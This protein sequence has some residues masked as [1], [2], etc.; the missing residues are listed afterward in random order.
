MVFGIGGK[1]LKF[2]I[3]SSKSTPKSQGGRAPG[4]FL[5]GSSVG[6][7]CHPWGIPATVAHVCGPKAD[8]RGGANLYH[9]AHPMNLRRHFV[10][11]AVAA[12]LS[13]LAA[14]SLA[15]DLPSLLSKPIIDAALPMKQVQAFC[16]ERIPRMPKVKTVSAWERQADRMRED[17]LNNVVFRGEAKVWRDADKEVEWLET[18]PGGPG[19]KIRKLRYEVLPGLWTAALLYEPDRLNGKVPVVMNVNGHD[20]KNGKAADYKQARCINQAKRGMLA[21]NVEWL[22]MGQLNTEG[23]NHYR[24]NQLDLCGASGLA[25]FYLAMSRGIDILLAHPNADPE[26]VAVAGLSGGGWQTIFISSLDTRVTLCNPVA[27]YSSFRTRVH[28]LSDLGDSEQTPN[29]L[30][31]VTDY[32]HLTAMLAPRPA[33][34]TF[35]AEDQCCFAANHALP[36]LLA[37]ATP[38][39]KLYNAESSLRYHVNY[40]PGSHNFEVDNRQA[41]YR[42]FGEFFYPHDPGFDP[43]ELP[44]VGEIKTA[45]ELEVALPEGNLDFQKLAARAMKDLPRDGEV[46]TRAGAAGKWRREK[47]R[48]LRK[49]VNAPSYKVEAEQVGAEAGDI[50]ATQWKLQLGDEWTVPAVEL[51]GAEAGGTSIVIADGGRASAER[52]IQEL[53]NQGRRVIAVD[54]FYF[55]ESRIAKRDFLFALLVAATGERPLGIQAAQLNAIAKWAGKAGS[56]QEVS[57]VGVGPRSSLIALTAAALDSRSIDALELHRPYSSLKDVIRDNGSVQKT[58]EVFCFGLLEVV[59]IRQLIALAAPRPVAIKVD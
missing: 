42:V 23:F 14:S 35:N 9:A 46:P 15:G 59:D 6:R 44:T 2:Q 39:Y 10:S 58:P 55:G 49:A 29:D 33:L 11:L 50:T 32:A 3:P 1:R 7:L 16:D 37:A 45:G 40:D 28:N 41:L 12:G 43:H 34:L 20:R 53:L 21:L 54:L 18:I 27:G 8:W 56:G 47:T 17:T 26:R 36:P 24:M 5:I 51:A 13:S 48:A 52:E 25:P 57:V 4:L 31:T 30:A 38:I 22:G 19:Y